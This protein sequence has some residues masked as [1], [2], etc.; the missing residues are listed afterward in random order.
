MFV[1]I[2]LAPLHLNSSYIV[3]YH[4]NHSSLVSFHVISPICCKI[5]TAQ[6]DWLPQCV[7]TWELGTY[8][9]GNLDDKAM[10]VAQQLYYYYGGMRGTGPQRTL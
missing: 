10:V 7:T 5:R 8:S 2:L 9:Q 3:S 1:G 4:A 6:Q